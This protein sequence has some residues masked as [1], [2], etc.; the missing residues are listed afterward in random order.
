MV[1]LLPRCVKCGSAV[2]D[3]VEKGGQVKVGHYVSSAWYCD[4]CLPKIKTEDYG[5]AS[6]ADVSPNTPP[7]DEAG[8]I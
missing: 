2:A 6:S 3:S 1:D 8:I 4:G 7:A 5:K